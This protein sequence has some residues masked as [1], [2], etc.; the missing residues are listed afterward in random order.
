MASGD[1]YTIQEDTLTNIGN[2]IRQMTDS[3][4]GITPEDMPDAIRSINTGYPVLYGTT[5]PTPAQGSDGQLYAKH[6]QVNGCEVTI[7]IYKPTDALT[8][9]ITITED[10]ETVYTATPSCT[11]FGEYAEVDTTITLSTGTYNLKHWGEDVQVRD[12][13]SQFVEINDITVG[14]AH[15]GQN[16]SYIVN[17]S[18]DVEVEYGGTAVTDVWLKI[19]TDWAPFMLSGSSGAQIVDITQ[20]EFDLL[21][22]EEKNNGTLYLITDGDVPNLDEMS[23]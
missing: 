22:Q 1:K 5:D 3:Q 23:F 8:V 13:E 15:N 10:N 4:E 12:A 2:A 9:S 20:A 7:T 19:A 18:K 11:I 14:F 17:E 6:A 21:S 16:S